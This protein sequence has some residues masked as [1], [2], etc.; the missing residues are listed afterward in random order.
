MRSKFSLFQTH[1]EFSKFFLEQK[2]Q[3]TSIAIDAT[4]GNGFDTLFLCER[5]ALGKIYSIDIQEEAILKAKKKVLETLGEIPSNLFF[6][7]QSH[8]EFPAEIPTGS[9]DLILYNLGYLPGSDK[10][11]KTYFE[12]TL[13]SVK[14]ALKL[15]AK[16]GLLS[17][18]CYSGHLE[19]EI[20]ESG[21][22]SFLKGLLPEEFCYTH[23]FF[24]NRT[25]APSLILI[26]K[27]L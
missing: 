21:L 15:L 24:A 26:Q 27:A 10:K 19:G 7:N 23:V 9:V 25:K 11:V 3:P 12:S 22:K 6:F 5:I 4:C 16:G 8:E 14:A 13:S 20:E 2:I 1:L 17:I 18:T